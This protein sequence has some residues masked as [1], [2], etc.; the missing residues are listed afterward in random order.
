[1]EP[2][3]KTPQAARAVGVREYTLHNWVRYGVI[4]PP[5]KDSSGHFS[6]GAEEADSRG[7]EK[8]DSGTLP[9]VKS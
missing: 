2:R 3:S 1:M 9:I 4:P 6:W 7:A 8:A 5:P